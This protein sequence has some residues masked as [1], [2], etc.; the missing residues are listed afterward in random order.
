MKLN[1]ARV[2]KQEALAA[3]RVV[4]NMKARETM[5][6]GT[7][8]VE[9]TGDERPKDGDSHKGKPSN[10]LYVPYSS[11]PLKKDMES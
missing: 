10:L 5:G 7:V 11:L 1:G 3:A 2:A 9:R 4:H 6:E 8:N